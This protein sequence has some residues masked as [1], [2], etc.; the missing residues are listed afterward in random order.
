MLNWIEGQLKIRGNFDKLLCFC[1]DG[2]I[3]VDKAAKHQNSF[4][5]EDKSFIRDCRYTTLEID[6]TFAH[7]VKTDYILVCAHDA[8]KTG[9]ITIVVPFKAQWRI[10]AE[11]LKK[12]CKAYHVDMRIQGFNRGSQ[13]SQLVE[14][15][16]GKIQQD[17]YI[18]YDNWDWDCPCPLFGG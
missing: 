9:L 5:C 10:S 4:I 14:I 11:S 1:R 7:F 17:T 6:Q 16:D 18:E 8:D 3:D 15:V 12:T 2:L 13:F